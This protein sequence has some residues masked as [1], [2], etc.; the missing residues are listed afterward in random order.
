M[1]GQMMAA[2]LVKPPDMTGIKQED[3]QIPVRDGSSIRAILVKP[4][5]GPPGPLAVLYHGGGWCIGM[6]EMEL[7]MQVVL[8]KNHGA[9]SISV[10]YRMA[11]EKV[12]PV[13]VEDC[14]DA[15]NW[16]SIVSSS[17]PQG[18][19]LITMIGRCKR[20][21]TRRGSEQRLY[22]RRQLGGRKHQRCTR[23][24]S[25]RQEAL[26]TVDRRLAEYPRYL[27]A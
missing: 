14:I 23:S 10:D 26:A 19:P 12:F 25:S 20:F 6:P 16:V 9:T 11:P 7:T 22:S 8:A 5:S 13:P 15:M 21:E 18:G 3:I 17:Y 4:E 24:R 1:L 2:G 27:L